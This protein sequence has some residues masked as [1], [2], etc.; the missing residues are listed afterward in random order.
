[1]KTKREQTVYANTMEELCKEIAFWT[2]VMMRVHSLVFIEGTLTWE[3]EKRFKG[4]L[5]YG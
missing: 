2:E 4:I 3:P 5:R 1:M